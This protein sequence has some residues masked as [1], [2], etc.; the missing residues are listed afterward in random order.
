MACKVHTAVYSL[1]QLADEMGLYIFTTHGEK[2]CYETNI[3]GNNYEVWK[4]RQP[5]VLNL[6]QNQFFPSAN[7][8]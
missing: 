3:L 5:R 4:Y 8:L 2:E 1:F 7:F 6:F